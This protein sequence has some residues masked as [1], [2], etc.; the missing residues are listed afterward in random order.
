MIEAPPSE[1]LVPFDGRFSID[2]AP[3]APGKG[4]AIP[5]KSALAQQVRRIAEAQR[6]LYAEDRFAVLLVFQAMDAAGKDG[7]IR[8]VFSGV[9]PAGC[10]VSSFREP[11]AIEL[12]HDFLWRTSRELPS[13]GTIGV[14]NRSH[15][16]EV[17]IVR[18]HPEILA[19]QRL[20]EQL[21]GPGLFLERFDSIRAHEQ[22][23]ARNGTV[24]LKF[25]LHVSRDEQRRRF[26]SRLKLPRKHWKFSAHDVAEAELWSEYMLAYQEALNETSRPW[27][28]WYVI[29]ADSK[30]FMHWH[31]AKIVADALEGLGLEY[32]QVSGTR[33]REL[34]RLRARLEAVDKAP[35]A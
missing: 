25:F 31:V 14:F 7:T 18:V 28:P 12:D 29:P 2:S 26:I 1:F 4:V 19:A 21:V 35:K 23:L 33:A 32:P 6:I 16:E 8:A 9:N 15:Y 3:T 22:H 30:P 27:A 10:H 5:K 17:L 20:P 11:S 13:R 24:V 34:A